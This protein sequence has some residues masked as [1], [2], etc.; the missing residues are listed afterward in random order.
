[1]LKLTIAGATRLTFTGLNSTQ[2]MYMEGLDLD[3]LA[4]SGY[5][6]R[7]PPAMI[8]SYSARK[9]CHAD[10]G[11]DAVPH[12]QILAQALAAGMVRVRLGLSVL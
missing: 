12:V 10:G 3:H 11:R 5:V 8:M 9:C 2:N 7:H 6:S 4:Y 1:M